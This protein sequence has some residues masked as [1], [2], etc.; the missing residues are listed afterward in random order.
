MLAKGCLQVPLDIDDGNTN[1]AADD[2]GC[3][4]AAAMQTLFKLT[5]NTTSI[6]AVVDDNVITH[7][8]ADQP[9]K[10]MQELEYQVWKH[11]TLNQLSQYRGEIRSGKL[12]VQ[13]SGLWFCPV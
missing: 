10:P 5:A 7:I 6:W 1:T 9:P 3:Y 2:F 12:I 13:E 11:H 4:Q 8:R